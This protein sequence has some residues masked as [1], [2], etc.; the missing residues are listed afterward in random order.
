MKN[1]LRKLGVFLIASMLLLTGVQQGTN[2]VWASRQTVEYGDGDIYEGNVNDGNGQKQGKGKYY[3][4]NGAVIA[5]TWKADYLTGQAT[6]IYP[7]RDKYTGAFSKDKRNGT[8]TEQEHI[9]LETEIPIKENGK[10]IK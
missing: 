4:V 10:T 5:G 1:G 2:E 9:V 6:V 7:N 8:G 3:C